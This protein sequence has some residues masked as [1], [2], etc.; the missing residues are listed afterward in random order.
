MESVLSIYNILIVFIPQNTYDYM[1][2]VL[3]MQSV[4]NV[5]EECYQRAWVTCQLFRF[6]LQ[7]LFSSVPDLIKNSPN[8][9]MAG[10]TKTRIHQP[11]DFA[12][13]LRP[14]GSNLQFCLLGCFIFVFE[15]M[16]HLYNENMKRQA[17]FPNPRMSFNLV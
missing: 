2:A 10:Q 1:I 5:R 17:L 12:K 8:F 7:N 6:R 9:L 15:I 14:R 3:C 11:T 16:G 4:V 13:F